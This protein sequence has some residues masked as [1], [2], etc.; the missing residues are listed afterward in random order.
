VRLSTVARSLDGF[1]NEVVD[2]LLVLGHPIYVL[3]ERRQ[4][5]VPGALEPHQL[6]ELLPM[7]R[8]GVDALL[9]DLAKLLPEGQVAVVAVFVFALVRQ[10]LEEAKGLVDHLLADGP[11]HLLLLQELPGDVQRQVL[12]VHH[13]AN[14][15]QPFR[16]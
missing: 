5:L 1:G 11:G 7:G 12:R 2:V 13:A 6:A 8:L 14:E 15:A 16:Q 3:L 10:L 9:Q 4:P